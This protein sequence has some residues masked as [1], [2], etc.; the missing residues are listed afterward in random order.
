M[1]GIVGVGRFTKGGLLKN[2]LDIFKQMLIGDCLRGLDGT[3]IARITQAG[4]SDWKK[5]H[6]APFDL[7]R[8][9]GVYSWLDR[10]VSSCDRVLIGHNRLASLGTK[11]STQNAHPFE[12]ENITL[13]HNGYISNTD[14]LHDNKKQK[15]DVDSE[16]LCYAI[17]HK[18]L[19]PT[20]EKITGAF[21][22]VIFDSSKKELYFFRNMERPMFLRHSPTE[23]RIIFGSEQKMLEWIADRNY[24]GISD[25]KFEEVPSRT[26]L[27]FDFEG[28]KTSRYIASPITYTPPLVPWCE[29]IP[30]SQTALFEPAESGFDADILEEE[31][32]AKREEK[33]KESALENLTPQRKGKPRIM[34]PPFY[35]GYRVHQLFQ[36][37]GLDSKRVS[38]HQEQYQVSGGLLEQETDNVFVQMFVKGRQSADAILDAHVTQAVLRSIEIYPDDIEE[39]GKARVVFHASHPNPLYGDKSTSK[40]ALLLVDSTTKH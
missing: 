6:G 13:V 36:F 5:I 29:T 24:V 22:L 32:M 16:E 37:V 3:G 34:R 10:S 26:L 14:S 25:Q 33:K 28:H 35:S 4:H 23:E 15:F 8:A 11:V 18:G 7:F 2:D 1:C 39:N 17:A 27:T 31:I 40:S 9:K 20:L 21:S 12:F 19:V 38:E 30:T